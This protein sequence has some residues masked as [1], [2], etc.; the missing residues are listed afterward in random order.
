METQKYTITNRIK[1]L[2]R[3]ALFAGAL[4]LNANAQSVFNGMRGPT[5]FQLDDRAGY[6]LREAKN[7][8]ETETLANNTILKYWNGKEKGIFGFVSIPQKEVRLEEKESRGIGDIAIGIGPRFEVPIKESK[9]SVL[10]YAGPVLPT[11]D[12]KVSPALGSGRRDYKA[13]LFGT[14]TD[15]TKKYEADFSLDYTL[16]E[17]EKVSDESSAGLVLGGRINNPLRAVVGGYANYK[18]DGAN[19]KDYTLNGRVNLRYTPLGSL[20]KRMHFELWADK[21]LAGKGDSAPKDSYALT[22]VARV[23]LGR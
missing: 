15:A 6:T 2:A 4:A 9:L 19:E 22:L 11:G 17:G 21:F 12:K 20:G 8:K 3:T 7:G 14:L 23:N 10:S 13:G 18:V 1:K 5:D 16:T